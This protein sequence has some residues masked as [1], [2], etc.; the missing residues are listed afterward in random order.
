MPGFDGTGPQGQG[1]RTGRGMGYCAPTGETN[2]QQPVYGVGRGGVPR[3]GGRG[4]AFG[5]GRGFAFGGRRGR[6]FRQRMWAP[7]PPMAMSK[8][9]EVAELREQASLL[10]DELT[11]INARLQE[12]SAE[13]EQ[14]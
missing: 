3:G 4:F 6:G 5:G 13:T 7:A 1:A 2:Q 8:A 10:Q 11:Q 12:L 14:E 9:Q